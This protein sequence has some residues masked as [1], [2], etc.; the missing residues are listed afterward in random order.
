MLE[1]AYLL[2]LHSC[3]FLWLRFDFCLLAMAG[4]NQLW[5]LLLLFL[6]L[7]QGQLQHLSTGASADGLHLRSQ[8]LCETHTTVESANLWVLLA[9]TLYTK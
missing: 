7:W 1:G 9:T 4:G 6:L 5:L 2:F 8:F 3:F